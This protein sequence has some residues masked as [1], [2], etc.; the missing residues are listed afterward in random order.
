MSLIIFLKQ[1]RRVFNVNCGEN[2]YLKAKTGSGLYL[3]EENIV[4]TKCKKKK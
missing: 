4:D 3:N 1:K 2:L